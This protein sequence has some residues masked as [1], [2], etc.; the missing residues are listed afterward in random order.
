MNIRIP[1]RIPRDCPIVQQQQHKFP[2]RFHHPPRAN[3]SKLLEAAAARRQREGSQ[4]PAAGARHSAFLATFMASAASLVARARLLPTVNDMTR[5]ASAPAATGIGIG[6]DMG[7][8][9]DMDM[10]MDMGMGM[11]MGADLMDINGFRKSV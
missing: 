7:M 6:I 3:W 2:R 1:S 10:D 5:S 11:D 9:M 8:G 4:V